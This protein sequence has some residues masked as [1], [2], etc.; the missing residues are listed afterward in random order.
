MSEYTDT[1]IIECNNQSSSEVR[2][3]NYTSP[4]SYTN[5]L[6]NSL[7]LQRGDKVSVDY[8][9]VNLSNAHMQN[10]RDSAT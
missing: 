6:D 9:F 2:G 7:R 4:A 1:T 8:C 3:G 10:Q 5:K